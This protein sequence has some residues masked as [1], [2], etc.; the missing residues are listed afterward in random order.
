MERRV[1]GGIL[2]HM[3]GYPI[4]LFQQ[5]MARHEATEAQREIIKG[6]FYVAPP[7]NSVADQLVARLSLKPSSSHMVL[8]GVGSGKT[9]QLMMVCEQLD[10]FDDTRARYID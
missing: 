8:G 3:A 1:G 7:G 10:R 4:D 2:R 6:G 9:T 5:H